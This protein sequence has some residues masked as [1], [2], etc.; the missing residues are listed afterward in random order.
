MTFYRELYL[1]I[2][3]L[4]LLINAKPNSSQERALSPPASLES[5]DDNSA[6]NIFP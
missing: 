2:D 4:Y 6:V 1:F 5:A 3:V